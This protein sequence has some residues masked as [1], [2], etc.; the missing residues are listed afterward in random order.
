M[1]DASGFLDERSKD[2]PWPHYQL[3]DWY[4]LLFGSK[5]VFSPAWAG[6]DPVNP[7]WQLGLSPQL[8]AFSSSLPE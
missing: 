6:P 2:T 4:T 5:H 1:S 7:P 3:C 8:P